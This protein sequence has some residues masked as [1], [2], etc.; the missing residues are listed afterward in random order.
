M[1]FLVFAIIFSTINHLLLKAFAHFRIN[2]LTAIVLNY[3][4]C[5]VIGYS[6]S[7]KLGSLEII[8]TQNWFPFSILQ[9]GI[10]VGCLLL[11]GITTEKQGVTI[12]SLATRLSVAIPTVAAFFLYDDII[13]VSKIIGILA[14]ILVLYL[15][16]VGDSRSIKTFSKISLLPII[17]FMAFGSHAV[18]LNYVQE[19]FLG[20]T[21]YHTYVMASFFSA[22]LISG[23]IMSWRLVKRQQSCNWKD[24][25]SGLVLGCTNYGSI[26]SLLR[27]LSVPEWQSSQLFPT[28][29]VAVVCLSSLGAWIFFNEKLHQRMQ[30]ALVIGVGSIILV[31]L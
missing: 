31:N 30:I 6:S 10:F 14:T 17:V 4:V 9:G 28:I 25:I 22:F 18:L 26:Y 19:Q 27:A 2:L 3:A 5:V 16:S 29:S 11:L 8:V 15:S 20:N 23:L 12:S 13:A 7:T 21:S 24:L 1:T